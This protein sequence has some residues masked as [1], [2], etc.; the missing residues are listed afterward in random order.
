[1]G[2]GSSVAAKAPPPSGSS[3]SS[4]AGGPA[5]GA[6]SHVSSSALEP[7]GGSGSGSSSGTAR[8]V[9]TRSNASAS[10]NSNGASTAGSSRSNKRGANAD[11]SQVVGASSTKY[12]VDS[13]EDGSSSAAAARRLGRGGSEVDA[14][15]KAESA[16]LQ[17]LALE[18]DKP[19]WREMHREYNADQGVNKPSR[20]E[21]SDNV[22]PTA[23][24]TARTGSS[25]APIEPI[26]LTHSRVSASDSSSQLTAGSPGVNPAARARQD[27]GATAGA[28]AASPQLQTTGPN[29]RIMAPPQIAAAQTKRAT[30]PGS[31]QQQQMTTTVLAPSVLPPMKAA[32]EGPPPGYEKNQHRSHHA[33]GHNDSNVMATAMRT[34][35]IADARGRPVNQFHAPYTPM[36]RPAPPSLDGQD[37]AERMDGSGHVPPSVRVGSSSG[38][39]PN[40]SSHPPFPHA[41]AHVKGGPHQPS[42][43]GQPP[44]F[45]GAITAVVHGSARNLLDKSKSETHEV[46]ETSDVKRNRA[47]LPS[48]LTHA[49]PTTGDWLNKRYIVNNY[50]LLDTLGTGSYGEVRHMLRVIL[51]A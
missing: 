47:Q 46:K 43:S 28:N 26:N 18:G 24:N 10:S 41:A 37:E 5:S 14:Q 7:S 40:T 34:G 50:I 23:P 3:L 13:D 1:M 31:A 22:A 35:G 45:G 38:N 42:H 33:G 32:I 8:G 44:S 6:R 49:K 29:S 48:K 27:N 17:K 2:A 21:W 11:S 12:A 20:I 16:R 15:A 19:T 4:R 36:Q 51:S 30:S 25:K 9:S 39:R